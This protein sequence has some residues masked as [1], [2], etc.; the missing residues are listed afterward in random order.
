MVERI[1]VKDLD[2]PYSAREVGVIFRIPR[3]HSEWESITYKRRRYQMHRGRD[4]NFINVSNPIKS[5]LTA[6]ANR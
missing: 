4:E 2:K 3:R 1:T 6:P 5:H